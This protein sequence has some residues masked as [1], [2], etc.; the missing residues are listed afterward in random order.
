MAT[1]TARALEAEAVMAMATEMETLER[2]A[3]AS[4]GRAAT[5]VATPI[6]SIPHLVTPP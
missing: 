1:V 5:T 3:P 4:V 6:A 2:V